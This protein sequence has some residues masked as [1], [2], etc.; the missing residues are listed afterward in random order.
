MRQIF[1]FLLFFSFFSSASFYYP[2]GLR[3][4]SDEDYIQYN[5]HW[6]FVKCSSYKKIKDDMQYLT[7]AYMKKE[8]F[9][10]YGLALCQIQQGKLEESLANFKK[11]VDNGSF[12]AAELLAEYYLSDGFRLPPSDLT[13][14]ETNLKNAIFYRERALEIMPHPDTVINGILISAKGDHRYL[15][16]RISLITYYTKQFAVHFES[17]KTK[18]GNT[19]LESL[20]KI[21]E[22]AEQCAKIRYRIHLW[23]KNIFINTIAYCENKKELA[24][25]LLPLERQRLQAARSH[26]R[27]TRPLNCKSLNKITKE[28]IAFYNKNM[29]IAVNLKKN[30]EDRI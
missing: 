5:E 30:L 11:A 9:D 22:T 15:G 3:G 16:G 23:H 25:K 19:T 1:I 21:L 17:P 26:C 24:E 10:Y 27:N 13:R 8:E 20:T 12:A 29:Q 18:V 28:I 2:Y 4:Y 7:A 14:N 6:R